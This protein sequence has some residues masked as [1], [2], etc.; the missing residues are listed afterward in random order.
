[1]PFGE[2]NLIQRP[3]CGRNRKEIREQILTKQVKIDKYN[4]PFGLSH[5]C[6]DF[7]NR[8]IHRKPDDRLGSLGPEE[9]KT[10]SWFSKF[11]WDDLEYECLNAPFCPPVK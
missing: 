6:I 4:I 5:A 2:S 10:H 9:L 8:L 7:I 1:M 11:P 3:Y